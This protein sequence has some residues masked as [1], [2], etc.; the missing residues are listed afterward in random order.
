IPY[1]IKLCKFTPSQISKEHAPLF[2]KEQKAALSIY[3][4]TSNQSDQFKNI[5]LKE[6]EKEEK[7]ITT[8]ISDIQKQ[9]EKEIKEIENIL[10]QTR[11]AILTIDGKIDGT[12]QL[13]KT[14][15]NATVVR[16]GLTYHQ[17]PQVKTL[18]Q[19]TANELDGTRTILDE[20]VKQIGN[21]KKIKNLDNFDTA[22]QEI[23]DIQKKIPQ[24]I[25]SY[26]NAQN[27]IEATLTIAN[28]IGVDHAKN[29]IKKLGEIQ[30]DSAQTL[31]TLDQAKDKY[32]AIL[33]EFNSLKTSLRKEP[34][35]KK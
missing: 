11:I 12:K 28:V 5:A 8:Q 9:H 17:P 29:T 14:F 3:Q 6:L 25:D 34:K 24:T 35:Y 31:K 21:I 13:C 19:L 26:K 2:S 10:E 20:T 33:H 22:I 32:E 27:R 4:E 1:I 15:E 18:A 23:T 16:V 7:L 30:K